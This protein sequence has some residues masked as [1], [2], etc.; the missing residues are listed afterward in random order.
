LT[1]RI[2]RT[3]GKYRLI[4]VETGKLAVNENGVPMDGGGH[5]DLSKAFRQAV[6]INEVP[7]RDTEQR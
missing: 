3:D 1:I 6:H 5:D 2:E 7:R 4:E